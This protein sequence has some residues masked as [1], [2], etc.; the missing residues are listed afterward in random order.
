MLSVIIPARNE[1]YLEKTIQNVLDNARGE[2]EVI[3][4]LDGYNPEPPI[5]IIDDRLVILKN[6]VPNGQRQSIN[7]GARIAKGKYVMKLDA[8]CA[9]DEGFDVK[10]AA[11][12]EYDWT[13]I[14]RMYNLDTITWKP[15]F[16]DDKEMALKRRKLHDYMYIGW[17]D[18]NEL[19]TLYY[20][21]KLNYKIHQNTNE[22]DDIMSC[23]G[24]CFFMWKERFW[25]LGGCDE[26]H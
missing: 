24:C 9:V 8:H 25:E 15:R 26:S 11:D 13:I 1:I 16:I 5:S 2:I 20:P 22:I 6:E 4:I 19:R 3:A 23:M 21:D 10:L 17:N 14:P 12:C 18:K 7:Q